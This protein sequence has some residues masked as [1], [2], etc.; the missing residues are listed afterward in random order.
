MGLGIGP[1]RGQTGFGDDHQ[2]ARDARAMGAS[3]W[4]GHTH[5]RPG[6]HTPI[7]AHLELLYSLSRS[8]DLAAIVS[9]PVWTFPG[10][11][12]ALRA[13]DAGR[14]GEQ[15]PEVTQC[16]RVGVEL[17]AVRGQ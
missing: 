6:P 13:G 7:L 8:G 11:A 4:R 9:A 14:G 17:R 1:V 2:H 16:D 3:P 15:V 5:T 12:S 10:P